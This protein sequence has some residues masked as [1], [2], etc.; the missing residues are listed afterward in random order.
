M[1]FLLPPGTVKQLVLMNKSN[2]QNRGM[3]LL[4]GTIY[5]QSLVD[6]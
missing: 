4:E 5:S 6:Y 3:W 1:F 2:Q